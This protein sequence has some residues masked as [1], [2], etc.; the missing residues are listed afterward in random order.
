[1]P[2]YTDIWYP[3][4]TY[5]QALLDTLWYR[6]IRQFFTYG[7]PEYTEAGQTYPHFELKAS[8]RWILSWPVRRY[9]KNRYR[10]ESVSVKIGKMYK[11]GISIG[12]LFFWDKKSVSVSVCYS[13]LKIGIGIGKVKIFKIGK[14]WF[15]VNRSIPTNKA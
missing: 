11:I 2:F 3:L 15:K 7:D 5:Y 4:S 13:I 6:K 1:M 12:M 8:L 14:N 9:L 10:L